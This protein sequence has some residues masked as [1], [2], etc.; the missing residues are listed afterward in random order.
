MSAVTFS[1]CLWDPPSH[2]L[3]PPLAL[4]PPWGGQKTEGS[5][6]KDMWSVFACQAVPW[7]QGSVYAHTHIRSQILPNGCMSMLFGLTRD[8][9]VGHRVDRSAKVKIVTPLCSALV[10]QRFDTF[11]IKLWNILS[12]NGK[13]S[14]YCWVIVLET[15]LDLSQSTIGLPWSCNTMAFFQVPCLLNTGAYFKPYQIMNI[16]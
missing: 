5:L 12:F 9:L 4:S 11:Y 1:V 3:S 2:P 8:L 7:E 13:F 10:T 16:N 6:W 15:W 14:V